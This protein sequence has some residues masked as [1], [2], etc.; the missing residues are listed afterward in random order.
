M[1]HV[2]WFKTGELNDGYLL[3]SERRITQAGLTKIGSK[4][5]ASWHNTVCHLLRVQL[6]VGGQREG[7][8]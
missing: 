4:L 3:T 1:G 8:P 5:S 7:H 2:N 6:T